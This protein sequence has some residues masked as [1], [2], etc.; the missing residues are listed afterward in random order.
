MTDNARPAVDSLNRFVEAQADCYADALAEIRR[1]RKE[2]HW[3]W[4]IFPQ[5]RGLGFSS[6]SQ[7]YAIASRAE[8]EAYLQHPVLGPRLVECAEA[9][10]SHGGRPAREI[11][12][13]PD[14]MKLRSSA[15]LFA[16]VSPEG[17]VFAQVLEVFFGGLDDAKTLELLAG[18]K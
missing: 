7:Y 3:M 15:T 8:A 13:S 9:A 10:L 12:G 2:T 14:D 1:G 16:S 4:F 6:T 17:S 18:A 5:F 11:F